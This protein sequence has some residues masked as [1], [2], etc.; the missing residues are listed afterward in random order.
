LAYHSAKLAQGLNRDLAYNLNWAVLD[1]EMDG[2][3][4]RR[5]SFVVSGICRVRTATDARPQ[6]SWPSLGSWPALPFGAGS[7][8]GVRPSRLPE[9]N[10]NFAARA[11]G[12]ECQV[13]AT[14]E[15]MRNKIANEA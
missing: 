3:R 13:D 12:W 14:A 4:A 7:T 5:V 10:F 9:G 11:I 6:Q 2:I 1:Q 15:L 8:P